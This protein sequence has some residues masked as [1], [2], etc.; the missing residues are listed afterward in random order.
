MR[1][2]PYQ[3]SP[4]TVE[5]TI[6][7]ITEMEN[8]TP[9]TTAIMEG[10]CRIHII[11]SR[12]TNFMR[13]DSLSC[14]CSRLSNNW[15]LISTKSCNATF[16]YPVNWSER[17]HKSATHGNNTMMMII[18]QQCDNVRS[19]LKGVCNTQCHSSIIISFQI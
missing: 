5:T 11:I 4:N 6:N 14:V 19:A 9:R 16:L 8:S 10:G 13:I 7:A 2:F 15:H 18:Y 1:F 12:A 17:S 3:T